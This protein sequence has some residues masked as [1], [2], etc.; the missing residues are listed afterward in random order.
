MWYV[1]FLGEY[2]SMVSPRVLELPAN[3]RSNNIQKLYVNI[4]RVHKF[5]GAVDEALEGLDPKF[6]N[7]EYRTDILRFFSFLMN[8][9]IGMYYGELFNETV[10]S[11]PSH[12]A[13][14][15]KCLS[16][17]ISFITPVPLPYW[18][19]NE[20]FPN[21]FDLDLFKKNLGE[22]ALR[23]LLD[24]KLIKMKDF[25]RKTK[26]CRTFALSKQLMWW[27]IGKRDDDFTLDNTYAVLDEIY[28][29]RRKQTR[30]LS[31]REMIEK[32][33]KKGLH[34]PCV[35]TY[36]IAPQKPLRTMLNEA[37]S[38]MCPLQVN[39]DKLV[40]STK[41]VKHRMIVQSFITNL[42]KNGCNII[43]KLPLI[44]EYMPQYKVAGVGSRSFEINTGFQ[45]LPNIL[46]W[47]C[48]VSGYNYDLKSCQTEIV[49]AELVKIGYNPEI[50]DCLS[51]KNLSKIVDDPSIYKVIKFGF[52]F[53]IGVSL[54]DKS[55]L[56]K[57]VMKST[58]SYWKTYDILAQFKEQTAELK[59]ALEHLVNTYLAKKVHNKAGDCVYNVNGA[60]FKLK[61]NKNGSN[62]T[63]SN[64]RRLLAHMIQGI[65]SNV[66]HTF[67][68]KNPQLKVVSLEH[69]GF[70]S[71]EPIGDTWDH[72]YLE[73]V[74]KH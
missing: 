55:A 3:W 35:A 41:H 31:L 45:N 54:Y 40:S 28:L 16:G 58:K 1:I 64:K 24:A 27:V 65:E 50:M 11:T 13:V 71:L 20:A 29:P 12:N 49:R 62:H 18:I 42:M 30:P 9:N 43:S 48:L 5:R 33:H 37:Y 63:R 61:Q 6:A 51:N 53:N 74:L 44:V 73:I 15:R 56:F 7:V 23:F 17:G 39:I 66:V 25:D 21:V 46:K 2:L 4:S 34:K 8:H 19:A 10:I 47:D 57:A 60:A 69:D 72:P 70:V 36:K 26:S 14:R 52:L 22:R 68:A 32:G 67:V 38:V 59:A